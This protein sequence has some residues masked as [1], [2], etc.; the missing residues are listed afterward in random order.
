MQ[1]TLPRALQPGK[2]QMTPIRPTYPP[3]GLG[4]LG[5]PQINQLYP[6][7]RS[8]PHPVLIKGIPGFPFSSPHLQFDPALLRTLQSQA[9]SLLPVQQVSPIFSASKMNSSLNTIPSHHQLSSVPVP[10]PPPQRTPQ[11]TSQRSPPTHTYKPHSPKESPSTPTSTSSTSEKKR[12]LDVIIESSPESDGS[13]K[14]RLRRTASEISRNFRCDMP[15][16]SKAYGSEGA[17]KMHIRLVRQPHRF[18]FCAFT[19]LSPFPCR[20]TLEA[21]GRPDLEAY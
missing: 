7:G 5:L 13:R 12:S 10:A 15:N 8:S 6:V 2:Q 17:L 18:P 14:K 16:C 9:F 3:R 1:R 19:Q 11:R 21:S 20:I 4:G